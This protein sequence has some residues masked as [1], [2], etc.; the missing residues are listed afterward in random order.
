MFGKEMILLMYSPLD[1]ALE[2]HKICISKF[3]CLECGVDCLL[4]NE[5]LRDFR[6]DDEV[7]S[8][9]RYLEHVELFDEAE[10]PNE[11]RVIL[12]KYRFNNGSFF[13]CVVGTR[14]I[15]QYIIEFTIWTKGEYNEEFTKKSICRRFG[16][17]YPYTIDYAA[18]KYMQFLNNLNIPVLGLANWASPLQVAIWYSFA[19][20]VEIERELRM[21]FDFLYTYGKKVNDN[22]EFK[23]HKYA[24]NTRNHIKYINYHTI[25]TLVWY[26]LPENINEVGH[27]SKFSQLINKNE[28]QIKNETRRIFKTD[29]RTNA[30]CSMFSRREMLVR[31]ERF[32]EAQRD[33]NTIVDNLRKFK[34]EN[35]LEGWGPKT[36]CCILQQAFRNPLAYP[37][38]TLIKKVSE[39]AFGMTGRSEW[40]LWRQALNEFMYPA[41]IEPILYQNAQDRYLVCGEDRAEGCIR[42]DL[43]T[44]GCPRYS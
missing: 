44:K 12:P 27:F 3:V 16:Y 8:W 37:I 42:C 18:P 41:L 24:V 26:D 25:K 29:Q 21:F 31:F 28:D 36:L 10:M 34:E 35:N 32:S 39:T 11:G 13:G 7:K 14:K 15:S 20:L 2:S 9:V 22:I 17:D 6:T 23:L 1:E 38:D 40:D 4:K 30:F 19:R 43:K 33:R 5:D